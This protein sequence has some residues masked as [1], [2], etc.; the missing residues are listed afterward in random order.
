M[1]C[2]SE[3]GQSANA[4]PACSVVTNAPMLIGS[5]AT[6]HVAVASFLIAGWTDSRGT[7]TKKLSGI[8]VVNECMTGLDTR[9]GLPGLETR[10]ANQ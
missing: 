5:N 4:I 9:P 8:Y 7:D 3:D 2:P 10:P 6:R 1:F